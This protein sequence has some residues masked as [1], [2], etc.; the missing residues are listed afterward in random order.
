MVNAPF[1]SLPGI[2]VIRLICPII[3]SV[4]SHAHMI[5]LRFSL[6]EL[7]SSSLEPANTAYCFSWAKKHLFWRPANIAYRLSWAIKKSVLASSR[8]DIKPSI[9]PT[10]KFGDGIYVALVAP[11]RLGILLKMFWAGWRTPP[12]YGSV[13][14]YHIFWIA[15]K[16][17]EM[18]FSA[19][20]W[21]WWVINAIN[22]LSMQSMSNQ[23]LKIL[24]PIDYSSITYWSSAIIND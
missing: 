22:D 5:S 12:I 20:R 15:L 2:V 24:W 11:I 19:T 17:V 4:F 21:Y 10:Q 13:T 14:E 1:F 8:R 23:W 18:S 6:E 16:N 9:L 7:L 3:K